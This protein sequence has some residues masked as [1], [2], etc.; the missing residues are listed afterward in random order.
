MIIA[1]SELDIGKEAVIKQ[2]EGGQEFQRRIASMGLRVGKTVRK[3]TS[4]P[5]NGLIVVEVDRASVAIGRGMAMN[6]FVEVKE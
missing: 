5:F 1:L 3:T 4:G 2:V 6:V